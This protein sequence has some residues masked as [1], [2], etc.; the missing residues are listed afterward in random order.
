MPE[1]ASLERELRL[2]GEA[3]TV[4][5]RGLVDTSNHPRLLAT[6]DQVLDELEEWCLDEL[7]GKELHARLREAHP[8]NAAD[9]S[10]ISGLLNLVET[11]RSAPRLAE[12]RQKLIDTINGTIFR[13]YSH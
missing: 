4:L 12:T 10:S 11:V 1:R 3:V 7:S 5:H 8:L 13:I 9:E 2:L 6:L